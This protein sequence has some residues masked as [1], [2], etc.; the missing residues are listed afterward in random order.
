MAKKAEIV[1]GEARAD[2]SKPYTQ[3]MGQIQRTGA[4]ILVLPSAVNGTDLGAQGWRDSLFL[5]YGIKPPDFPSHCHGCGAA[6]KV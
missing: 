5:R 2:V 3:W 4:W 6:F 1:L